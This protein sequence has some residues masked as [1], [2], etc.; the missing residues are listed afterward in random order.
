M[1]YNSPRT[2][3]YKL[4]IRADLY[5]DLHMR[6][7]HRSLPSLHDEDQDVG[8]TTR[9]ALT[10]H[11]SPAQVRGNSAQE[12]YVNRGS[13]RAGLSHTHSR[14]GGRAAASPD[15]HTRSGEAVPLS[16]KGYSPP[17]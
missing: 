12:R 3:R 10:L 1:A 11:V 14:A 17:F 7:D 2:C 6:F 9:V 13:V 5:L 4:I 16:V 8:S 15:T